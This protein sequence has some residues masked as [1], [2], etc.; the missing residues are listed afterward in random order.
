MNKFKRIE[1]NENVVY[2]GQV[3]DEGEIEGVG[4]LTNYYGAQSQIFEGADLQLND[5]KLSGLVRVIFGSAMPHKFYRGGFVDNMRHG[6]G[7]Y[8]ARD[9]RTRTGLFVENQYRHLGMLA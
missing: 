9:G 1:F 4:R 5:G 3:N 6:M 2:E 7:T 8:E